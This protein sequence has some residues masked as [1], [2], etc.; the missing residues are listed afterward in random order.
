MENSLLQIREQSVLWLQNIGLSQ[1]LAVGVQSF[2]VLILILVLSWLVGKLAKVL[3]K[4][5]IPSFIQK[6]KNK[7][8]D[9][10]VE[11]NVFSILSYYLFG[12]VFFWLDQ[13]IAS[14]VMRRF[15][16]TLTSTYFIIVSLILVNAVLN[17]LHDIY[18]SVHK[19]RNASI[20]IYLQLLKVLIFSFGGIVIVSIFANKNFIDILT[21]LGAMLT[22]LLI[23]YKDTILGF[24]AGISLSANKM[25]KVGDWISVPHHNADGTVI[26]IGLS[27]VRVQNWDKT[28]TTIP[29][30]R[31]VSESFTNWKGM[32]ESGGRRIKRHLL[33]DINSVRFLTE[34]ELEKFKSFRLLNKYIEDKLKDIDKSNE[35]V[36][37]LVN[38]RRLTN[39]GTFKKYMENYLKNTGYVNPNLTFIVRQL[40]ST[41]VGVP[42]E[43]YFFSKEQAWVKYEQIQSDIFDHFFA[44]LP[45]F[46]LSA[47][48]NISAASLESLSK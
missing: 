41:E 8:D 44:I 45:E 46:G 30:Y 20:K 10:L 3:M 13:F 21:G 37:G 33:I 40:Q 4:S 31:L 26:D 5:I 25:L 17:I 42:I 35:G 39:I 32:E 1:K 14:E 36:S 23:V 29:P 18:R 11:Y 38:Q 22:I 7:W 19:K 47:F 16:Q 27:A 2:I 9:L 24:V 43:V 34:E 12:I 48:E 15:I 28:I 6:T